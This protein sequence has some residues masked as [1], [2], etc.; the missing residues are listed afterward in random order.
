MHI[1]HP[2]KYPFDLFICK[3]R[4]I[5]SLEELMQFLCSFIIEISVDEIDK[6]KVCFELSDNLNLTGNQIIIGLR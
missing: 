5:D 2:L 3:Q 6:F 1:Y 4:F